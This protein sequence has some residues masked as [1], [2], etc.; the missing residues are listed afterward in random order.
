MKSLPGRVGSVLLLAIVF[1]VPLGA[2]LKIEK[3]E[4]PANSTN[5]FAPKQ[6]QVWFKDAQVVRTAKI[7]LTGPAGLVKLAIPVSDGRSISASVVGGIPDGAYVATW[8]SVS[9]DGRVQRGQFRFI[10]KTR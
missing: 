2:Q 3:T 4:P 8:Q 6:I 9:N 10:V 1:S 5:N 7:N